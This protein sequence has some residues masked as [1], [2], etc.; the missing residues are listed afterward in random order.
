M[1]DSR[2]HIGPKS[3]LCVVSSLLEFLHVG[4]SAVAANGFSSPR[5]D[6]MVQSTAYCAVSG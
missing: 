4:L 6:V 5:I 3:H 2:Y 1:T